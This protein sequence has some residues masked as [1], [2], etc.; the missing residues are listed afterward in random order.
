MPPKVK[1]RP[2][3]PDQVA[4]EGLTPAPEVKFEPAEGDGI[5]VG[6]GEVDAV[7]NFYLEEVDFLKLQARK[8]R[9]ASCAAQ[10]ETLRLKAELI[11][12]KMREEVNR[13]TRQAAS[14]DR[15]AKVH[16]ETISDQLTELS[17][18]YDIDFKNPTVVVDE[19]QGRIIVTDPTQGL[20][21][22]SRQEE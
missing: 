11:Q 20:P 22:L 17:K 7:G 3:V 12:L 14:F 9:K 1:K 2:Q 4:E 5:P 16:D 18:K 15:A 10:A 8:E 6:P 21:R 19:E 13:F